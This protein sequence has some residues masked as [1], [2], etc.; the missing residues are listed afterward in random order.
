[1]EDGAARTDIPDGA[2]LVLAVSGGP[3]STA[4]LHAAAAL[5][6]ARDWQLVV[7]HLDHGLRPESGDDARFVTDAADA[8]GLPWRLRRTDVAAQAKQDGS[9]VEEAG[10]LARYAFLDEVADSL[11]PKSLVVTAHTANDQAE[12]VLLN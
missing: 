5:A 2:S 12:T 7:A 1:M 3:D 9:G 11:G 8:L 4:L 6:P 10:R